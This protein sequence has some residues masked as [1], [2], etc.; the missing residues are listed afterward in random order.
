MTVRSNALLVALL[1]AAVAGFGAMVLF[2][3]TSLI[4]ANRRAVHIGDALVRAEVVITPER[5][6]RGLSGQKALGANE[7][8]LF[9]YPQPGTYSF[10]MKDMLFPIDIIWI[11]DNTVVAID[12]DVPVPAAGQEPKLYAPPV[13]INRVLEVNAGFAKKHHIKAGNSVQVQ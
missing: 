8:M 13:P 7:G 9:V 10:W 3:G 6:R 2:Y 11:R 12:K 5:M 4:S 1:V